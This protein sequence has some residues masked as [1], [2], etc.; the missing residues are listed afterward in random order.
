METCPRDEHWP[1][2]AIV[3]GVVDVL[4][5]QADEDATPYVR[6]VITLDNILPAII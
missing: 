6:I 3:P 4:E 5:V 2:V 1:A